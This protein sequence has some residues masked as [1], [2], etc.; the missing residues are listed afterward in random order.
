MGSFFNNGPKCL[1]LIVKS[2]YISYIKIYRENKCWFENWIFKNIFLKIYRSQTDYNIT[3]DTEQLQIIT[4]L[5]TYIY[6]IV[7]HNVLIIKTMKLVF[8]ASLL[9]T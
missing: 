1:K 7:K 3:H 2:S 5:S 9:S 8:V 6:D 4:E